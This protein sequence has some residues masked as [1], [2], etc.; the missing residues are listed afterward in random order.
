MA[1]G[2]WSIGPGGS[3]VIPSLVGLFICLFV[4]SLSFTNRCCWTL[5]LLDPLEEP[6]DFL[7]TLTSLSL[8]SHTLNPFSSL[9]TLSSS[10]LQRRQNFI[11]DE[12]TTSHD[13]PTTMMR[14]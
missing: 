9:Q 12:V 3:I 5:S 4:F 14:D 8:L 6:W 13:R 7:F 2:L 10:H 1:Y 11:N